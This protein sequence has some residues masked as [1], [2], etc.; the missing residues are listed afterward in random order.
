MDLRARCPVIQ[1]PRQAFPADLEYLIDR[2]V[3]GAWMYTGALENRP[4][5]IRRMAR[6]RPLW[7]A[8]A[9]TLALARFPWTVSTLLKQEGLECPRVLPFFLQQYLWPARPA[10]FPLNGRWLIKPR[11]S[12]GGHGIE[13]YKERRPDRY[14]KVYIQ[15]YVQ[16]EALSALFV[17]T[18]NQALCLGVTR[19][20]VGENWLHAPPFHYCGSI[21]P[22]PIGPDL[23]GRLQRIGEVLSAGCGL[24]GLFGIDGVLSENAFWPVEINPRYTASV[25]VLEYATG[26]QALAW[27]RRVFDATAPEPVPVA[28][29]GS[30]VVGKAI[31]FARADLTFPLDG[32]WLRTLQRMGPIEEMPE[33]ADIPEAGQEIRPGQPVLTL[34]V[35][36]GSLDACREALRER[37]AD[38]DRW[39]FER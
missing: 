23:L 5:L 8:G 4:R 7:G 1:V 21:G 13:F 35:R 34:F 14:K 15:E 6:R 26:L 10:P 30:P 24:F 17:G 38:L 9:E 29:Q 25:E 27:H 12:A 33:F 37:A 39:L 18:V 28:L 3:A 2:E 20:L 16:G 36:A 11:D 22:F 32:P 19:Q 31:L